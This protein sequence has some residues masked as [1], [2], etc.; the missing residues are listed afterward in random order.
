V[1]RCLR[2]VAVFVIPAVLVVGC[3]QRT[4]ETITLHEPD[5]TI[6]H[7]TPLLVHLRADGT[8]ALNSAPKDSSA[9]AVWLQRDLPQRKDGERAV[10]VQVDSGR[11]TADLRWIVA[12]IERADGRA[13]RVVP[14]CTYLIS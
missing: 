14:T 7:Q 13:Y 11:N 4:N 5:S 10:F 6:C 2:R 9:L 1:L 8:F 12:S 3:G